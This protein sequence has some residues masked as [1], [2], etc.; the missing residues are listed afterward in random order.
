MSQATSRVTVMPDKML[1]KIALQLAA[2]LPS[3][4]TMDWNLKESARAW[5]RLLVRRILREY[6]YPPDQ[7]T[8]AIETVI[9]RAEI[10]ADELTA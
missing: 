1:A 2:D 4:A 9:K 6:G 10:F 8:A 3:S 5:M 7:Q